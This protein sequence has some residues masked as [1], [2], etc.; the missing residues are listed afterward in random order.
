MTT[1]ARA[2]EA[3]S[4]ADSLK[5][6]NDVIAAAATY[7]SAAVLFGNFAEEAFDR[8]AAYR[9]A[10]RCA[11]SAAACL[12]RAADRYAQASADEKPLRVV[13]PKPRRLQ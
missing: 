1:R 10:E 13:N 9:D 5:A 4:V 8:A 6:N 11:R 3:E 12:D 7:M 2:V